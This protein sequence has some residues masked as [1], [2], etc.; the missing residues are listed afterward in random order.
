[1]PEHPGLLL[2]AGIFTVL[3]VASGVG[4]LLRVRVARRQPHALI[5]N[6][7]ARVNAWWVMAALVGLA[8]RV[9]P[10]G[11][12]LLFGFA[13]FVALREFV[14]PSP[15][16]GGDR[17]MRLGAFYLALP[18]QYLLIALGEGRLLALLLPA[19]AFVALPIIAVL[20]GDPRDLLRRAARL[21]WG[22]MLCVLGISHAPALLTL[23]PVGQGGRGGLLLVFL[24]L[25]TQSSDVLQYVWGKLAGR[26][27]L[28]PAVSPS[29]TV[30]GAV[31]GVLSAT[32]LGTG[33]AWMTPFTP[34]QAALVSLAITLLG[35]LGGL[36]L[37]AVKRDRGIKDWG[38]LVPGHGGVLDRLDSLCFSAPVFYWIV[39]AG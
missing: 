34:P 8:L 22:L 14:P 6:L 37:S 23:D 2:A 11:V 1:M 25:V 31:G 39:R 28:A 7:V 20:A 17:A 3:V 26:R 18:A 15:E 35:L 36:V 30:E 9:G 5:D 24:L 19:Y 13:S 21:Q 12:A 16:G 27:P 33:L 29:K 32:A 38:T 10:V 4:Y